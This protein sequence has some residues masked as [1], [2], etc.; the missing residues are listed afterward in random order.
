MMTSNNA[1]NGRELQRLQRLARREDRISVLEE[2]ALDE[3]TPAEQAELDGLTSRSFFKEQ[4]DPSAF[5]DEHR[6]FKASHNEAFV[7]LVKYC[8][9]ASLLSSNDNKKRKH[10]NK[11][12]INVFS[13]DGPDAGTTSALRT[14]AGL[15]PEQCY[16]A[17]R[18]VS[19]CDSLVS[20]GLLPEENVAHA[21]ASE[22]LGKEGQFANVVFSAYYLDGCGGHVPQLVDM[23]SCAL[24]RGDTGCD[25]V[26]PV[27][28]GFS[29]VGGNRD[30][31]DK[32]Q[33]V[34]RNVVLMA[35]KCGL[36]VVHALDDPERYGI[37]PTVRKVS[38]G[39]MTTWL[40]LEPGT[41]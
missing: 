30:V 4:Y 37:C 15:A 7:A 29:I 17:N 21:S 26:G 14:M 33:D 22:A 11:K 35:R 18:H 38:G 9:S 3:R 5:S 32:E 1:N 24:L 40:M 31:I 19:T 12:L 16:V 20:S 23:L 6:A 28:V 41:V 39:T 25:S 8:Q 36:S 13:L 27:A 2:L 34:I 10:D